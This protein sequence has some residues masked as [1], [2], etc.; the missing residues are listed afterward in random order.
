MG[1]LTGAESAAMTDAHIAA[2]LIAGEPFAEDSAF[3]FAT[4]AGGHGGTCIQH[5]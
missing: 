5:H 3:D 2:G 1:F 4:R